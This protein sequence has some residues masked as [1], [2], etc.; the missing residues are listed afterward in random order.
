MYVLWKILSPQR[1]DSN[2][3]WDAL[4]LRVECQDVLPGPQSYRKQRVL[5]EFVPLL[6]WVP[7]GQFLR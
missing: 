3:S 5:T 6:D 1:Q 4:P 2:T 7:Q